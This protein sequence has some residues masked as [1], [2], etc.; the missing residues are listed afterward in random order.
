[1]PVLYGSSRFKKY[2][3]ARK[4]W[5]SVLRVTRFKL[6]YGQQCDVSCLTCMTAVRVVPLSVW[7][8][9]SPFAWLSSMPGQVHIGGAK[10]YENRRKEGK[11]RRTT[12]EQMELTNNN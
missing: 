7:Y 1:M 8:R 6:T 2:D 11:T 10:G 3:T 12:F 9:S 4:V 5:V